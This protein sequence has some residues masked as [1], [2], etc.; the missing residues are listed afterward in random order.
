MAVGDA[1]AARDVRRVGVQPARCA[2]R[3]A[4]R[5][6][7]RALGPSLAQF[8]ISGPLADPT[9]ELRDENG[10]LVQ[11]NDN[12]K[13]TQQTEIEATGLQP[14]NDMESTVFETLAPGAY[15]A[16]VAGKG[17]LAGVGLVEVYRL[18]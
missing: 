2:N 17:D 13:E 5:V 15:T 3:R 1:L 10:V 8:G 16:V 18:P 9:L 14:T 6:V 4:E 12:W 11:S 7:V